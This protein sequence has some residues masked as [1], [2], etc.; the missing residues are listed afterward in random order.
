MEV[1][2]QFRVDRDD[3]TR[4]EAVVSAVSTNSS[5]TVL[6]MLVN[7]HEVFS[8]KPVANVK[9][10]KRQSYFLIRRSLK[11]KYNV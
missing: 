4:R 1:D 2:F 10:G 9:Y 11:E 7:E 8:A 3:C 6:M 5:V